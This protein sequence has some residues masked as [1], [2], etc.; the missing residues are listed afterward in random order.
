MWSVGI[1]H[2]PL[3]TSDFK[4]LSQTSHYKLKIHTNLRQFDFDFEFEMCPHYTL[5]LH[6]QGLIPAKHL[7]KV[8]VS[9]EPFTHFKFNWFY[10]Q[11]ILC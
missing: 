1:L 10:L 5:K 4:L 2:I 7:N 11:L 8:W 6:T 9:V 3:H